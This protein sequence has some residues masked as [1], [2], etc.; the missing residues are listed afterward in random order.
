M[1][2]DFGHVKNIPLVTFGLFGIHDLNIDIPNRVISLFNCVEY[3]LEQEVRV[4]PSNASGFFRTH[5]F[6]AELGFDVDLD[7]LERS[8]L[9][10]MVY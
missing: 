2:P 3:V 4:L 8:I 7:V 10:G 1:R 9:C 5:V 6:H